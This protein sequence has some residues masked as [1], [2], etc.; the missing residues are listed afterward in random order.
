MI[1]PISSEEFTHKT[2]CESRMNSSGII[3][4]V[5]S[6]ILNKTEM[7]CNVVSKPYP[8]WLIPH[9]SMRVW[10]CLRLNLVVELLFIHM[11]LAGLIEILIVNQY[12]GQQS[13]FFQPL[14]QEKN[15]V[16][17]SLQIRCNICCRWNHYT[18]QE[19]SEDDGPSMMIM[20]LDE[21]YCYICLKCEI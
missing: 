9:N 17:M 6:F 4:I 10:L 7:M 1:F 11:F 15:I 16:I 12:L 3:V 19:E 5:K 13:M 20:Q 21:E 2:N 18:Q 8:T 14:S